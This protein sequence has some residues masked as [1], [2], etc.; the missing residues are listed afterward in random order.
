MCVFSTLQ[1][2]KYSE[3]NLHL[4]TNKNVFQDD[5]AIFYILVIVYFLE[6]V[7]REISSK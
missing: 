7:V 3:T 5:S 6:H 2:Y 4:P 1:A